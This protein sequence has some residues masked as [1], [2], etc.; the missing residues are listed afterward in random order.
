M[1]EQTQLDYLAECAEYFIEENEFSLN[2]SELATEGFLLDGK[3]F[4]HIDLS[5]P[6]H[7][8]QEKSLVSAE[9]YSINSEENY[10]TDPEVQAELERLVSIYDPTKEYLVYLH[11]QIEEPEEQHFNLFRICPLFNVVKKPSRISKKQIRKRLKR[12]QQA[13]QTLLILN[14][15]NPD[16][17][18]HNLG[19]WMKEIKWFN[20]WGDGAFS[21]MIDSSPEF[22]AILP[23]DLK[24]DVVT[25]PVQ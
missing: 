14:T 7:E 19:K 15:S 25:I 10:F 3:G 21:V 12:M 18:G 2:C 8:N 4:I 6:S 11:A 20:N 24:E 23:D 17:M 13:G 9:W 22:P 16:F 1:D 5:A